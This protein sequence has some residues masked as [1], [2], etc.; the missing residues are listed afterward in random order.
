[1]TVMGLQT[2]ILVALGRVF[3]LLPVVS[4]ILMPQCQL[5]ETSPATIDLARI[6]QEILRVRSVDR[7]CRPRDAL[8]LV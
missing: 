5:T 6:G 2:L 7:Q 8:D 4:V 1:M 3:G